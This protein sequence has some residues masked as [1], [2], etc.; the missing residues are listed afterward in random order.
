MRHTG[1]LT[2]CAAMLAM[3]A[4]AMAETMPC[5]PESTVNVDLTDMALEG[6]NLVVNLAINT[7]GV[8]MPSK[9][10]TVYQPMMVLDGDTALFANFAVDGRKRWMHDLED[11][12]ANPIV[13]KGWSKENPGTLLTSAMQGNGYQ[14]TDN[15]GNSYSLTLSVPYSEWMATATLIMDCRLYECSLCVK[16]YD[17]IAQQF[18]PLAQ[19]NFVPEVFVA[20][21]EYSEPTNEIVKMRN[22]QEAAYLDFKV[23]QTNIL[24]NYRNNAV[25]LKRMKANID[26]IRNDEDINV[27]SITIHGMASPEGSYALNEKL[28]K[29]RTDALR[30]Y[31]IKQYKLPKDFVKSTYEPVINWAGLRQ[32]LENNEIENGKA[33]LDIVNS[34]LPD[35]DRNQKIKTTYPSQYKWLLEN[36]YPGLRV[37]E[38]FVDYDVREFTEVA[39]IVEVMGNNPEK[40][41]VYEM[42]EAAT[43]QGEDSALF[44]EAVGISVDTYP[45]DPTANLNAGLLA[46]K[47][48]DYSAAGKYL[49]KAG[50]SDAAKLARA[51]LEA[52]CGDKDKALKA[53]KA[54]ENCSDASVAK[55]AKAAAKNLENIIKSSGRKFNRL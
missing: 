49:D 26:S 27:R 40:L 4:P 18:F 25:E 42:F 28:A 30:D 9:L 31:L 17:I 10:K 52:T 22:M 33:I 5:G 41:S 43:S 50:D 20:E 37:S 35:F 19:A 53:F 45:D 44:A 11:N 3:G 36:V 23:S 24:P 15:G 2:I 46:M 7:N 47:N 32:W 13:F 1:F 14:L 34:D 55:A 6:D 8:Q 16:S 54:L 12:T 38:Y 21:I 39:E 29:G 51:Q 48:G